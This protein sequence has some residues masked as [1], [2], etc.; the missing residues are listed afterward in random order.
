MSLLFGDR[1]SKRDAFAYPSIP[2]NSASGSYG[3]SPIDLRNA[4]SSLRKVAV[5]A[6]VNLIAGLCSSM[7]IDA[8]TSTG[9]TKRPVVL[10][11]FFTDPD[12]SGQ[13]VSDWLYQLYFSLLLRGNVVGRILSRDNSGRPTQIMLLHPDRVSLRE[14]PDG[15]VWTYEGRTIPSEEVWH[16]RAF[17]A[18]GCRLGLSPI[19]LHSTTIGQGLS[20]AAFG[21]KF[22]QDGAHPSAILTQADARE[23][24]QDA[25]TTVKARFMAAVRGSREPVVLSGGWEYKPIQINPEES[26]FLD[27]QK[28][29]AAECARIFG[30]G[31]PEVLGYE[32]GGSLTYSNVEARSLDLMKFSLNRWLVW[33]EQT[34]SR[35]IFGTGFMKFNRGALLS[36]DL[37]TRYQAH[38]IALD[39]DWATVDEVRALEDWTP[40]A[41]P[42]STKVAKAAEGLG[43]LVRAGF[44][45]SAAAKALGLAPIEHTG[46]V[47]IT[48]Q[49]VSP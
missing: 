12:G 33:A 21:L 48:V 15:P 31:V 13:G 2:P 10:P 20:A 16:R 47:P 36:T 38:A 39:N 46:Y 22:F 9:G 3:S 24:T 7:P 49:Q 14:T 27:T 28:Y 32:T 17:P 11:S 4:E 45:P 8:Y 18:P 19:A 43:A 40:I 34:L 26:Q 41:Q 25:A 44:D 30:P 6:S 1:Q 23:I 35:D 37:L 5:F 29:T 42:E